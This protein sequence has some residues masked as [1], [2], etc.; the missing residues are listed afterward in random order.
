[1]GGKRFLA[2]FNLRTLGGV[3]GGIGRG[4]ECESVRFLA[5]A[6]VALSFPVRVVREVQDVEATTHA[7]SMERLDWLLSPSLPGP[8][9]W[10]EW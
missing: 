1:M 5:E 6:S 10:P 4:C 3:L 8:E 9:F 7:N 2:K